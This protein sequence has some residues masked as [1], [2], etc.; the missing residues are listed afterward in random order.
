MRRRDI[1]FACL[2]WGGLLAAL[3]W[4]LNTQ[5]RWVQEN[6]PIQVQRPPAAPTGSTE[7]EMPPASTTG[8]IGPIDDDTRSAM[9]RNLGARKAK[10]AAA[11][12]R[13]RPKQ[14]VPKKPPPPE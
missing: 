11:I 4:A 7:P 14:A 6:K 3:V 2:A 1:V 12:P 8:V 5:F 13:M 10:Q 9:A